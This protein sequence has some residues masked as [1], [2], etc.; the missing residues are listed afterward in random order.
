MN[1]QEKGI[2]RYVGYLQ[3][4]HR[5][6]R[7]TTEHKIRSAWLLA[8]TFGKPGKQLCFQNKWLL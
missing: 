4:L 5:D 8:R 3:R 2:V 7:S 6:A 1:I